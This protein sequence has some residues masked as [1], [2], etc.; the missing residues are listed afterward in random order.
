MVSWRAQHKGGESKF[1]FVAKHA[2]ANVF[3]WEVRDAYGLLC[4]S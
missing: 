4:G 2:K 3:V 1:K